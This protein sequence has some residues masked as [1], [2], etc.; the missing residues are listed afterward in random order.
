MNADMRQR[1]SLTTWKRE[2]RHDHSNASDEKPLG[3]YS[4]EALEAIDAVNELCT[5]AGQNEGDT[6]IAWDADDW[7]AAGGWQ[8]V[9]DDFGV[10]GE[11]TDEELAAAVERA[12]EE[13]LHSGHCDE[14]LGAASYFAW[15]REK[16][17]SA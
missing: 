11:T 10:T 14:L 15:L 4:P 6:V 8:S 5:A 7:F 13:A 9:A 2:N 17:V 1:R 16:L 12:E 3:C